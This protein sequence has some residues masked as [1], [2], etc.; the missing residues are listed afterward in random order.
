M[1]QASCHGQAV[2]VRTDFL[3][4][5]TLAK[6]PGGVAAVEFALVEIGLPIPPLYRQIGNQVM[7]V[8]LVHNHHAG[9][10]QCR[11]IA[12]IVPRI[13]ADV[14]NRKVGG[15]GVE[16]VCPRRINPHR[17]IVL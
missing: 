1:Q 2:I 10:S 9:V 7:Q 3:P 4:A 12:E 11:F 15:S 17:R 8:G 16:Q 13:I 6:G 14:I 5:D